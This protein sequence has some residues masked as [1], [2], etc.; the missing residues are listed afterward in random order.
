MN[1][2]ITIQK[3]DVKKLFKSSFLQPQRQK[4]DD[5][6]AQ[7]KKVIILAGPTGTGKSQLAMMLAEAMGGEIISADSMQVYKD[8]DIGTAKVS[9]DD[10]LRI[11]HHLL[12]IR[13]VDDPYNVVDF[14]Y[15]ARHCCQTL[16]DRD[17][18][19]I[20][21]GGS[22]FYIHSLIFGPPS[23]PPS[24]P[25]LRKAIEDEFEQKGAEALFEKL[26]TMDPDYAKTITVHDKQKIVR[27]IEI[28]TLTGERVSQLSWKERMQPLHYDFRCWFLHRPRSV[29]YERIEKR[30]EAM[31]NQGLLEEVI[32][33]EKSGIR[34]NPSASQAIGYRQSLDFLDSD[35]SDEAYEKF[36][37]DFKK[38]SRHYAKR[39]FT[40]FKKEPYFTWLDLDLHD[41]ETAV[42]II[43]SDFERTL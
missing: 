6:R 35:R 5:D 32:Q 1:G 43:L 23:G 26:H 9:E 3:D 2:G 11:P 4:I 22:G 39:Q 31:L 7:K 17:V 16:H 29:L 19:P 38:V 20:V 12:D 24:V 42:D 28:I 40:W 13:K 21:V 15:E 41:P 33:L 25:S 34:E 37:A 14:Y 8:M 27:A 18:T 30:C 10:R 36:V